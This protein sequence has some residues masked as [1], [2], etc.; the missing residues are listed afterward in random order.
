MEKGLIK[1]VFT[2]NKDGEEYVTK[3]G[4]PFLKVMVVVGDNAYYDAFFFTPAAHWKF[5]S[6]FGA[7]GKIAPSADDIAFKD[8]EALV[9]SHVLVRVGKD[10][11]GYDVVNLYKKIVEEPKMD[12]PA[13]D[14]NL[15]GSDDD[16]DLLEN[17]PF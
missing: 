9:G 14:I 3:N 2:S 11:K 17:V 4:N 12:K 13:P 5:E 6:L 1:G 16:E 15:S 7:C 8:V 10:K